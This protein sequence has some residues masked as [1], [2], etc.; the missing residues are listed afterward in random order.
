M[1]RLLAFSLRIRQLTLQFAQT[2][3]PA[4][5]PRELIK[6]VEHQLLLSD[7]STSVLPSDRLLPT[8]L[9]AQSTM[10][11]STRPE[12]VLVQIM[13]ID[14]VAHPALGLLDTL[15]EKRESRRVAA[16][17]REKKDGEE[18]DNP[19]K[20]QRGLVRLTLSDGHSQCEGFEYRMIQ[21]LGLEEVKLGCKVRLF[22]LWHRFSREVAKR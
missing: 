5:T 21:G 18:E 16:L 19:G 6:K 7:L 22:S 2:H 12:R 13:A 14:E 17:G 9:P 1:V 3:Y 11:F 15:K 10:L 8:P 20:Y 4:T